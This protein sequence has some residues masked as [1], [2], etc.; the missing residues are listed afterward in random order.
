MAYPGY[1][2]SFLPL[3]PTKSVTAAIKWLSQI[4]LLTFASEQL[5]PIPLCIAYLHIHQ[6]PLHLL[7]PPPPLLP[8]RSFTYEV[9]NRSRTPGIVRQMALYY[10]EAPAVHPKVPNLTWEERMGTMSLNLGFCPPLKLKLHKK[11]C[12]MFCK[13]QKR[14]RIMTSERLSITPI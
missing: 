10:L 12:L 9:L 11:P 3:L 13:F 2:C 14:A 6:R 1:F 8:I 5:S 7:P 4:H